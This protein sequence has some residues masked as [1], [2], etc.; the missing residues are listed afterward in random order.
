MTKTIAQEQLLRRLR[1]DLGPT[2]AQAMV[3]SLLFPLETSCVIIIFYSFL[4]FPRCRV[5]I[6]KESESRHSEEV[7]GAVFFDV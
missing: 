6:A 5:H 2:E 1:H 3:L 4:F 7:L